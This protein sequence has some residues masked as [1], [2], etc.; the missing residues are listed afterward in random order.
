MSLR[1]RVLVADDEPLARGMVAAL[2]RE[3]ADVERVVE[4]RNGKTLLDT[5]ARETADIV[6]LDIEMPGLTGLEVAAA[7]AASATGA[8]APAVVFITAFAQYAA[9]AFG[10]EAVD[11]VLK[12]F[13]DERF[14][15]ALQR[16]KRRVRE[17]R[18]GELA[19][20]TA[21]VLGG[22]AV[23][24]PPAPSADADGYLQQI[25]VKDG[26][27]TTLVRV[28]DVIWIKAEDYY[29]QI[30][31]RRGRHLLRASLATL[32]ERLDPKTFLRVHRNA[33]VNV[34]EVQ[35]VRNTGS[36]L[37]V[38]LSDG[39]AI[40]VSRARRTHAESLLLPRLR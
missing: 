39:A 29:V 2:A 12:P 4:C 10:V 16:A 20:Q 38:V 30:H 19:T 36:G 23:T 7:L 25:P 34:S 31:A 18:L 22:G 11:Y 35:E 32:E 9:P 14:R 1:F 5:L 26:E 8:S 21:A 37:T 33:L 15:D 28:Q 3:D 40:P 17:R 13:S 24:A 6:F 27:R